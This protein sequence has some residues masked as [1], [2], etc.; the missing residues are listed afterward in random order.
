VTS[1]PPGRDG[2]RAAVPEPETFDAT[3]RGGARVSPLNASGPP[4]VEAPMVLRLESSIAAAAFALCLVTAAPTAHA[5]GSDTEPIGMVFG[6]SLVGGVVA[7]VLM[8]RLLVRRE[9]ET[10]I[11]GLGLGFGIVDLI[12]GGLL[13]GFGT[14]AGEDFGIVFGTLGAVALAV[15]IVS[16]VMGAVGE[17]RDRGVRPHRRLRRT[18]EPLR[19]PAAAS[20]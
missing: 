8:G 7:D 9:R 14:F 10:A 1:T 12:G 4:V 3:A 6:I 19:L 13:V 11:F 16:V 18:T 20:G 17:A 2:Q 5:A 15:G